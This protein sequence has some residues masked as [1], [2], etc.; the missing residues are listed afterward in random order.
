MALESTTLKYLNLYIY[1][2]LSSPFSISLNVFPKTK[3]RKKIGIIQNFLQAKAETFFSKADDF[4]SSGVLPLVIKI[5][6]SLTWSHI[7]KIT[8]T[9]MLLK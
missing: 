1:L 3:W 6:G 7:S 9:S 5:N 8:D 4:L 2:L